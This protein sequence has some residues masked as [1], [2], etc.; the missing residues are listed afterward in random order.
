[1]KVRLLYAHDRHLAG[2]II[3]VSLETGRRLISLGIAVYE[4][5][6]LHKTID[7]PPKD[8]MMTKKKTK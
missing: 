7:K 8:K 3:P 1:M 4:D 2:E 6:S 5:S